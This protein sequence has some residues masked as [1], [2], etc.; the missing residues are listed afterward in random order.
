VDH[1]EDLPRR[2]PDPLHEPDL[3]LVLATDGILVDHAS[4]EVL[5]VCRSLQGAGL[6]DA[7]ELEQAQ[8]RLQLWSQILQE[9]TPGSGPLLDVAP[10]LPRFAADMSA[11]AFVRVAG[12]E[13]ALIPIAGT[14]PR[15]CTAGGAP[16]HELDQRLGMALLLDHKEQAEHAMLVDLA[17]NDVARICEVGTREVL[18]PLQL[19]RYSH[20]QHLVTR[21]H[22]RL[23]EDLDALDAYRVCA[24]MG[25]LSGAPKLRAMELIR[26]HECTA[27]GFY[28]GAMGYLT[29]Q[30]DLETCI[31][32]RSLRW[33]SGTYFARAGA[34][35]VQDSD[36]ER[37]L[38]ETLHKAR[39]PLL[40]IAQAEGR[41]S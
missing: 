7:C 2:L 33:R 13:V 32:I 6:D 20:V 15:G 9:A 17:R 5:V 29:R 36:P 1:F 28:G 38:E 8:A 14:A 23:S 12:G 21:V 41:D 37:E 18:A 40:A 27:R 34:G 25:T 10:D 31:V 11:E 19:E 4:G 39:A 22:G 24:N 26:T 30:G 3:N 16:D 35:I